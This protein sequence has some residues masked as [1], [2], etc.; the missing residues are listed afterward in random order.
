[1][2]RWLHR[3][4]GAL[5]LLVRE[6]VQD[7]RGRSDDPGP[8]H[9]RLEQPRGFFYQE[10]ERLKACIAHEAALSVSV[11]TGGTM[12]EHLEAA[13]NSVRPSPGRDAARARL[14]GPPVP[15]S[16]AYLRSILY[17][18]HGRS[19]ASM[20]GLLPLSDTTVRHWCENNG[21]QLEPGEIEALK[22]L[23]GV[24]LSEAQKAKPK[25]QPRAEPPAG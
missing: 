19:G 24:L 7:P 22:M 6:R 16:L 9:H 3:W 17:Q 15:A 21:I 1:M 8:G 10:L 25:Q 14:E 23:D 18:L 13:A 4:R 12:R 2:V 20:G 5:A 11:E